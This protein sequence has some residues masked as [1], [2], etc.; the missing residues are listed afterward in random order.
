MTRNL[1]AKQETITEK[2]SPTCLCHLTI[3]VI[4]KSNK[5]RVQNTLG[6]VITISAVASPLEEN[7]RRSGC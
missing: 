1:V 7:Q 4:R 2:N 6:T 5:V 3:E